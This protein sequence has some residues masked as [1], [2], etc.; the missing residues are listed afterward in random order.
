[1]LGIVDETCTVELVYA[2]VEG[3]SATIV[4][5]GVGFAISGYKCKLNGERLAQC[6]FLK[7]F[8]IK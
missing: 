5:R 1:M 7:S 6:M 8:T 4:F 2:N 3:N